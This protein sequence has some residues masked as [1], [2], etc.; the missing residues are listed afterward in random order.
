V[1]FFNL[2]VF[3][4]FPPSFRLRNRFPSSLP[5]GF[6]N[7]TL[8]LFQ[9][10]N[11]YFSDVAS[12]FLVRVCAISTVLFI[13]TRCRGPGTIDH[14]CL[15]QAGDCERFSSP[16]RREAN[17]LLKRK[18]RRGREGPF[19]PRVKETGSSIRQEQRASKTDDRTTENVWPSCWV[20]NTSNNILKSQSALPHSILSR[21]FLDPSSAR[22]YVEVILMDLSTRLTYYVSCFTMVK[23]REEGLSRSEV[24]RESSRRSRWG[25]RPSTSLSDSGLRIDA[26]FAQSESWT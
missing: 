7:R 20:T 15:S 1:F 18:L 22:A 16:L 26:I 21:G 19:E 6:I 14:A 23:S 13:M 3:F 24:W 9:I 12:S 10:S 25:I 17:E 5:L 4:S 8:L 2:E 11:P